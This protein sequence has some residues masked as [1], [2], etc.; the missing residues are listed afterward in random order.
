MEE[1]G[2]TTEAAVC[3]LNE[4]EAENEVALT[5][6]M[7]AIQDVEQKLREGNYILEEFEKKQDTNLNFF[8][9]VGVYEEDGKKRDILR[10]V[11]EQKEK[12]VQFE[13]KLEQYR[14]R[15]EQLSLL[16]DL[17]LEVQKKGTEKSV[18]KEKVA[19]SRERGL[20]LLETQEYER[21]RIARDLHD[22]SVQSLTGLVHKTEFCIR[23]MDM[24][25]VRVK[26]ELTTMIETI[27]SII[28]G[29][30]EIIYDLRPMSL[31]NLGFGATMDAYCAQLRKNYDIEV[32]CNAEEK[33]PELPPIWKV[34][35]YRIL[36]EACSNA[37]KHANA[38][39]I[40]ISLS[41]AEGNVHLE[42]KDDGIGF[43]AN[44]LT[45]PMQE[46]DKLHGFGL[47]MMR[48][49]A[50]LLGGNAAV[51]SAPGEGTVVTVI[52]PFKTEK[53]EKDGEN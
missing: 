14:Y 25:T 13:K 53:E 40:E 32:N 6:V 36:Q 18:E 10:F 17:L 30:R 51:V 47:M 26:L 4:L 9:P 46:E 1:K 34:T 45:E 24:D 7:E 43:D 12:L 52:I 37:V 48:E 49:R 16:Q 3:F 5:D 39:K 8:S 2:F 44:V 50:G 19:V 41:Y 22:S 15:K 20:Y 35:L 28:N 21:N 31:N 27:K 29:M 33:E 23:L 42:I 11:E 38:S